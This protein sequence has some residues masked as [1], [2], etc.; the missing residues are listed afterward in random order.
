MKRHVYVHVFVRAHMYVYIST[1]SSQLPTHTHPKAY[2]RTLTYHTH[3]PH[4]HT[5]HPPF[6]P[7]PLTHSLSHT[8]TYSNGGTSRGPASAGLHNT[9]ADSAAEMDVSL[10][11]GS[12]SNRLPGSSVGKRRRDVDNWEDPPRDL[13]LDM[14]ISPH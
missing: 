9:T 14:S 8:H 7:L 10:V 13:G 12:A 4:T 6:I 1:D 11:P 3:M 2:P 5:P